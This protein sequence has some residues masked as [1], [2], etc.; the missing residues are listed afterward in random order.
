[1]SGVSSE[2][3]NILQQ[4]L[5]DQSQSVVPSIELQLQSRGL[6]H[7]DLNVFIP[8]FFNKSTVFISL[9]KMYI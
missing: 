6:Q 9:L 5:S 8:T 7:L 4:I 3:E 2:T 1:M